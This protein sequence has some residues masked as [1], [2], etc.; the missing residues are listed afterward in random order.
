MR[1]GNEVAEVLKIMR[2][3]KRFYK[4]YLPIEAINAGKKMMGKIEGLWE[5]VRES[6]F[7][8]V[9]SEIPCESP[10][11]A[12][13]WYS[14]LLGIVKDP[15]VFYDFTRYLRSH[16]HAFS[17]NTQ[18][19]LYYQLNGLLFLYPE[20]NCEKNKLELWYFYKEIKI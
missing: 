20:L 4:N 9:K 6:I 8:L 14:I 18:C 15:S 1:F 3:E 5:D 2:D 11:E 13:W 7:Q 12:V 16:S 10:Y 17:V 19:F